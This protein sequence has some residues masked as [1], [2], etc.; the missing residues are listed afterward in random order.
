MLCVNL[1]SG[2]TGEAR[3]YLEL[4]AG[5]KELMA[6]VAVAG[7][8]GSAFCDPYRCLGSTGRDQAAQTEM[9]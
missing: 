2:D 6:K 9:S 1:G 8:E 7:H 3:E 5:L 4:W